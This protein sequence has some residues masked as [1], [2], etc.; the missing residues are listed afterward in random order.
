[1]NSVPNR[2]LTLTIALFMG[3]L[4]VASASK[5]KMIELDAS[6]VTKRTNLRRDVHSFRSK[7][8]K[9]F[10]DCKITFILCAK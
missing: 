10:G 7:A 8:I 2:S 9:A 6:F 5:S 3:L 4:A 1:M